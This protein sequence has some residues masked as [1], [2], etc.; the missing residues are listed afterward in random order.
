MSECG[1]CGL[2]RASTGCMRGP[3]CVQGGCFADEEFEVCVS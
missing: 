1:V 2:V 3:R